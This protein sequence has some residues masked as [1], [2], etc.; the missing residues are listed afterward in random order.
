MLCQ[1]LQ[2]DKEQDATLRC[3]EIFK[4]RMITA[5][6][7][8]NVYSKAA[9]DEAIDN[10]DP[11]HCLVYSGIPVRE[12]KASGS[13]ESG[14]GKQ[15]TGIQ[16]ATW[17]PVPLEVAASDKQDNAITALLGWTLLEKTSV[18]I[19]KVMEG[20]ANIV[21]EQLD[22]AVDQCVADKISPDGLFQK[23]VVCHKKC[24]TEKS[25]GAITDVN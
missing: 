1:S 11:T 19:D 6:Q 16:N 23:S 8:K 3:D 9:F 13:S 10:R 5:E 4:R 7:A 18:D 2:D 15:L 22:E 24:R 21:F 17:I 20:A 25:S 14:N 12:R